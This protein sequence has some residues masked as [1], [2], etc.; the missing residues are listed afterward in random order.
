MELIRQ[1]F[2]LASISFAA[3][4]AAGTIPMMANVR[5][6]SYLLRS[7]TGIAA[8][9]LI[10]SAM[11]VVIPEGFEIAGDYAGVA[12]LAGFIMMMLLECFGFGHDIHE[13]HHTHAQDHG[14]GHVNHPPDT[15]KALL[16]LSLHALTDGLAIGASLTTNEINI[17]TSIFIAII[18]HKLP[19]ALSVGVFCLHE[20]RDMR[21]ALRDLVLFSIATPITLLITYFILGDLQS[22][23]VGTIMLFAAGTFLYVAT[24]DVLPD[25]HNTE[26]G[27]STIIHV[28]IGAALMVALILGLGANE[29]LEHT[30]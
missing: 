23:L 22:N 7:M 9:L 12:L 1:P 4:L 27:R 14:H 10:V 16:G 29:L 11:M 15:K 26:T 3:A 21:K 25:V 5:E 2:L 13:E 6:K 8:G 20:H 28:S 30:H 24:V 18:A 17:T 19:A